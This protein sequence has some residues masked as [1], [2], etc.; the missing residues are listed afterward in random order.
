MRYYAIVQC[1]RCYNVFEFFFG[2]QKIEKSP[3]KV[4][5]YSIFQNVAHRATVYRTG[6]HMIPLSKYVH[7]GCLTLKSAK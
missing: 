7:T 1:R 2:P 3:S 5:K 4:A 6:P